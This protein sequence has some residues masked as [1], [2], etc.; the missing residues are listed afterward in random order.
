MRAETLLLLPRLCRRIAPTTR[1]HTTAAS[2]GAAR[3]KLNATMLSHAE[4]KSIPARCEHH[5]LFAAIFIMAGSATVAATQ[6]LA[7]T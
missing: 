4:S 6:A 2:E 7:S 5:I 1:Q 3:G